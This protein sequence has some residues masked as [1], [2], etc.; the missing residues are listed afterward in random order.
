M[1]R[2]EIQQIDGC[3]GRGGYS[4]RYAG[5]AKTQEGK[6]FLQH[7]LKV[8]RRASKERAHLLSADQGFKKLSS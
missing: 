2:V 7:N 6:R 5:E 3:I 4:G 8:A 1:N